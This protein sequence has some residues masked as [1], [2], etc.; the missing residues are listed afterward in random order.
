[1]A[2]TLPP[3]DKRCKATSKQTGERCRQPI[4]RD[5]PE[6]AVCRFHGGSSKKWK[7]KV[8]RDRLETEVNNVFRRLD[9]VPV[10]NP[11]DELKK[12]AGQVVA[13]KDLLAEKVDDLKKQYRYDT[14]M[15]EHIRGEVILFERSMDRAAHVLGL[16][17]KLNIDER[18]ASIAEDTA[19]QLQNAMLAAFDEAGLGIQDADQKSRIT[20]AFT[21]QL[22]LLPAA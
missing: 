4:G 22:R 18:L 6:I 3:D 8:I 11:L 1:M 7:A 17:A 2:R 15:G 21:R 13:W 14:E 12:L 19:R 20:A 9:I 16:I 5:F 10:E